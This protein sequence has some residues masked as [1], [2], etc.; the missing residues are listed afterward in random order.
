VAYELGKPQSP[1]LLLEQLTPASQPVTAAFLS[2]SC[3]SFPPTHAVAWQLD[4]AAPLPFVCTQQK[5]AAGQFA[6]PLQA[7]AVPPPP[8]PSR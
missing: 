2:Q 6:A 3:A 4:V 7:R 1:M 8:P 5:A